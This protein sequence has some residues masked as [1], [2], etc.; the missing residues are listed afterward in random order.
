[1]TREEASPS[2]GLSFK[3]KDEERFAGEE[4]EEANYDS[5]TNGFE[6]NIKE[7]NDS[8][9]VASIKPK[10]DDTVSLKN[11][12]EENDDVLT[13]DKT[14]TS[15]TKEEDDDATTLFDE[16]ID[17]KEEGNEEEKSEALSENELDLRG[18][19]IS[20]EEQRMEY[21]ET[22][23]AKLLKANEI[24]LACE[25]G[26]RHQLRSLARSEYGLVSDGI[27]QVACKVVF[28]FFFVYI[29]CILFTNTYQY[30]NEPMD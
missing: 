30:S 15:I 1:M 29:I 2:E 17:E 12:E 20:P 21:E 22:A 19:N 10:N 5:K 3:G 8:E 27:R 4:E 13:N 25:M 18:R 6:S 26:D 28:L 11:E 14:A 7:E 24:R 23:Q 9:P 16:M